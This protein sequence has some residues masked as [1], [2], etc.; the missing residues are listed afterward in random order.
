ML[1]IRLVLAYGFYEP[2]IHKWV[3]IHAVGEWFASMDYPLPL[4]NA[5]IAATTEMIG[6]VLLSLGLLTRLISVPLVVIMIVAIM[7]VHLTHGFAAGNNGFEIPL[8][9]ILLLTTLV[10]VG[11]GK[12]SID[13]LIFKDEK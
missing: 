5:Y 6:V 1:V 13:Q 10:S 4:F 2:A 3:D 9:Y 11:P 8:Y 7:T 12:Y